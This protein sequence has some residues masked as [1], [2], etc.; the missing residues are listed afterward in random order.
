[1]LFIFVVH[2]LE[3]KVSTRKTYVKKASKNF[4]T[5]T[6]EA[7]HIDLS[8]RCFIKRWHDFIVQCSL[9]STFERQ[10]HR[11]FKDF[12]L[13]PSWNNSVQCQVS[14]W[15]VSYLAAHCVAK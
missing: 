3:E 12:N 1:M 6:T 13:L 11:S 15:F 10:T 5:N 8:K 4:L 7:F 9:N 14:A 2:V